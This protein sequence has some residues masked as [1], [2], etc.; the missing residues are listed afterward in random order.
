[1]PTATAAA[2]TL[3]TLPS[4]MQTPAAATAAAA[5]RPTDRYFVRPVGVLAELLG[6]AEL[7]EDD[8]LLRLRELGL[9]TYP[10]PLLGAGLLEKLPEVLA[11]EVLSQLEPTDVA[12][13]G[14]ANRA[15]RAAVVAFGVP[16]EEVETSDDEGTG[17]GSE[18]AE[19]GAHLLWVEDFVGSVERLAWAKARGCPWDESVCAWAA[20]YGQLE[21]LK[22]AW[23]RRCPWNW[24]AVC[25]NAAWGGHLEVLQWAREHG[26]QFDQWEELPCV[27]AHGGHLEVL[28]WVHEHGCPLHLSTCK[29]AAMNGHLELLKWAREHHCPWTEETSYAAVQG[30]HTDMLRWAREHGCP[31][32]A[33][34]RDKAGATMGYFDNL[35]LFDSPNVPTSI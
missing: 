34:T 35:P 1:M 20:E 32:T 30:G 25:V 4:A 6:A 17:G 33:A 23:E 3:R 2:R 22:W 26:C 27:A 5:E 7:G 24:R 19:G 11:A 9:I 29:L 12:M 16:Q 10:S 8:L 28:R 31:W 21:V 15:C 14:Q 18:E 13:F